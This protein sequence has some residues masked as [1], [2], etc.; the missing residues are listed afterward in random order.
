MIEGVVDVEAASD[1]F[2]T[3]TKDERMHKHDEFSAKM[4][5][6]HLFNYVSPK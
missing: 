2:L 4:E 6:S 3:S 5:Q 1:I